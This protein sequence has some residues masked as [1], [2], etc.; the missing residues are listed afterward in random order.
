MAANESVTCQA[1]IAKRE[2]DKK[3]KE[4]HESDN[5]SAQLGKR[6]DISE[7]LG[8]L[9]NS[10]ARVESESD[11]DEP[12]PLPQRRDTKHNKSHKDHEPEPSFQS[13]QQAA[14]PIYGSSYVPTPNSA[15]TNGKYEREEQGFTPGAAN[16]DNCCRKASDEEG[17]GPVY[18]LLP[19]VAGPDHHIE[20]GETCTPD[21]SDERE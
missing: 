16:H 17:S 5:K 13:G 12:G 9:P 2:K 20:S 3:A 8:L 1:K 6:I 11:S 19:D 18:N 7:D 14:A 15:L 4:K 10:C 21:S